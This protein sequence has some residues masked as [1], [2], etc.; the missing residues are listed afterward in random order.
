MNID[1]F[2]GDADGL[3]ALLQWRLTFPEPATRVS[4]V[5]RDNALLR[6]V[7]AGTGDQVLVLDITFDNNRDDLQRLLA[8]GTKVTYFDHHYPGETFEHPG[9][10]LTIDESPTVCTSLLVNKHLGGRQLDWA[11]C[12]AFGDNLPAVATPM[13]AEA[14]HSAADIQALRELGELLN[15][16][17]YGSTLGDL[18][19]DP[20]VLFERL[21]THRTP[22]AFIEDSPE[23][24][25]LKAGFAD[26]M[27][28]ADGAV[29]IEQTDTAAVYQL[30]DAPWARRVIGVWANLL[31]Q[32]HPSR[33]HLIFCPDGQGT[34][35]ASVRTARTSPHGA[36][37]FCRRFAGGGGRAP[38]AGINRVSP[39]LVAEITQQFVESF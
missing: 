19:F 14:G 12:G 31:S 38:A 39:S 27:A 3:C 21:H 26:D 5:K 23:F 9:L 25:T 15:Y 36:A 17:G 22:F 24:R 13:A 6:R 10:S 16:N 30:P 35:T 11:L 34:L 20:V 2:N 28:R 18:H 29:A 1:V 32:K 7:S 37:D 4:G 33:A 8:Q